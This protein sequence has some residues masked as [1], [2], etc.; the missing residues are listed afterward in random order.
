M[1]LMLLGAV[2]LRYTSLD[3]LDIGNGGYAYGV[4]AGSITGER[5]SGAL[6]LTNLA[7]RRPD[8]VNEPTLRGLLTLRDGAR[9]WVELDGIAILRTEDQARV[10]VMS[11]RFRTGES[12]YEW[13][14]TVFGILEGVL[15]VSPGG[16]TARCRLFECRATL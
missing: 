13:L 6:Q 8:N 15:D 5:L 16:G 11:C 10:F 14:N 2:E 12:R 3:V 7:R 1:E 4:M 9:A